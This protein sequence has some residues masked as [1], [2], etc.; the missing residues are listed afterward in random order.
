MPQRI[1]ANRKYRFLRIIQF[2]D[3]TIKSTGALFQK[4]FTDICGAFKEFNREAALW[5]KI[6]K[7]YTI[8]TMIAASD[9]V[10]K[11]RNGQ[12]MQ[13]LIR[14]TSL[15]MMAEPEEF[16]ETEKGKSPV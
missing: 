2:P 5:K 9:I 16:V 6:R 14:K 7:I 12:N 10:K 13:D 8:K 4:A 1:P 3:I 11:L 15:V